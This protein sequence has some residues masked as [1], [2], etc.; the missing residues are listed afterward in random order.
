LI[1]EFFAREN[2]RMGNA[3]IGLAEAIRALRQELTEAI[4]AGTDAPMRFR[5]SPVELTLNV[6]VTR[7]AGGKIAWHVLGLSGSRSTDTTQ[8]LKLRLEPI[9]R[10]EDG[11]Y[12][13]DFLIASVGDSTAPATFGP[14]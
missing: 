6:A 1:F 14:R 13:A 5:P 10:Q 3:G 4:E 2:F 12:T 9:W 7:E 8:E 11:S